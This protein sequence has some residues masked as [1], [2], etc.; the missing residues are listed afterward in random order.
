MNFGEFPRVR[1]ASLPTA[2]E[3]LEKLTADLGGPRLF[4]KRDDMTGLATGGNKTRKLEFA[5]AAALEEGADCVITSGGIQSNHARQTA[6]AAARLGLGCE[7]VLRHSPHSEDQNYLEN[8]NIL[9]DRL[10]GANIHRH[11]PGS[12]R[13][14]LM[15]ALADELRS[16]GKHP[17]IIPLGA[18]YPI[19]NLGYANAALEIAYQAG[20]LGLSIDAIVT[21]SSSGGT[22]A[23]LAAGFDTLGYPIQLFGVEVDNDPHCLEKTIAPQIEATKALMGH[24][25]DLEHARVEILFGHAGEG[26]GLPSDEMRAAVKQVAQSEGLL[27]DPVYSGKAMAGLIALAKSGRFGPDANILFLH[28][29]GVSGLFGNYAQLDA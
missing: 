14:A 11:P 22:L 4:V 5:M 15:A 27:L 6:A 17:Y 10:L 18:S 7:L 24:K 21:A 20:E 9:L 28:T 29:G 3:P 2:I 19:G 23:G 26:Y 13:D 8:G 16:A 12:D 1:L 25:G